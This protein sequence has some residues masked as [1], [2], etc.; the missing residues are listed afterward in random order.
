MTKAQNHWQNDIVF[1]MR[2]LNRKVYRS[3]NSG[4]PGELYGQKCKVPQNEIPE[5]ALWQRKNKTVAQE[6]KI[7]YQNCLGTV[8]NRCERFDKRKTEMS[9]EK[10]MRSE[11]LKAAECEPKL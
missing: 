1:L 6:R 5:T 9:S 3:T 2:R 11:T 7:K 4:M 8:A 10:I